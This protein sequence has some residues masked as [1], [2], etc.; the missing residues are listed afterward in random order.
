M[1]IQ[2]V[3]RPYLT[4]LEAAVSGL[5]AIAGENEARCQSN[6]Q[7]LTA[8]RYSGIRAAYWRSFNVIRRAKSIR[9]ELRPSPPCM[10]EPLTAGDIQE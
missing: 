7:P 5:Y 1:K 2:R 6:E 10:H 9:D 3:Y 4:A 8:A